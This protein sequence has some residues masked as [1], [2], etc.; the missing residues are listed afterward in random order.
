M[1]IYEQRHT[2][3]FF[4]MIDVIA[5]LMDSKHQAGVSKRLDK[6]HHSAGQLCTTTSSISPVTR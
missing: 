1:S 6:L 3:F 4:L 5:A 2:I